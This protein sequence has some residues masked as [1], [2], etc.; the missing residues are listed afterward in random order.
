VLLSI[1][2]K[3]ECLHLLHVTGCTPKVIAHAITV[4]ELAKFIADSINRKNPNL[5]SFAHIEAGALLHDIGRSALHS[6]HHACAGAA[7]CRSHQFDEKICNIVLHHIGA[8][9]LASEAQELGL[10]P[11]DYMPISL[12]EKVVAHADNLVM[13]KHIISIQMRIQIAQKKDI[14]PVAIRR[15]I[16]LHQEISGLCMIPIEDF[17]IEGALIVHNVQE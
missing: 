2:S 16:D 7:I 5:V 9:I 13:G 6:I 8:G 4:F 3:T 14:S 15:M 10:P 12:E 11:V 17:H 1:P